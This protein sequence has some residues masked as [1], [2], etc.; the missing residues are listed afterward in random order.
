MVTCNL[1]ILNTLSSYS[2]KKM[3]LFYWE[4]RAIRC[5]SHLILNESGCKAVVIMKENCYVFL[6]KQGSL[7]HSDINPDT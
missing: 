6:T 4:K 1:I 2:G 5:H 7:I 3:R